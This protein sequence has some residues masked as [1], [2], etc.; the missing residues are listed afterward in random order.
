[1]LFNQNTAESHS[2]IVQEKLAE[3]FISEIFNVLKD[4]FGLD[5]A[6]RHLK[7]DL[8]ETLL[9]DGVSIDVCLKSES[10]ES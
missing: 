1:M 9:P 8:D 6:K 3:M 7:N 4:A 5:A 10:A 2:Q